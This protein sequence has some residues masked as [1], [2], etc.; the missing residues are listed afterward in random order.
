MGITEK[1]VKNLIILILLLI[2]LTGFGAFFH[3]VRMFLVQIY[4]PLSKIQVDYLSLPHVL[5]YSIFFLFIELF[6]LIVTDKLMQAL[7]LFMNP[8]SYDDARE[9]VHEAN[10]FYLLGIELIP[11]LFFLII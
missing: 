4:D 9:L 1:I 2:I 5:A 7:V 8:P 10:F 3:W 6:K 11:P